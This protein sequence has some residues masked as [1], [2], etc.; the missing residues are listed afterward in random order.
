MASTGEGS[1]ANESEGERLDQ[2]P[3]ALLCT[4]MSKL[5][6]GSICSIASTCTAFRASASHLFG[7]I[8]NFHLL[9]RSLKLDCE[10]LDDSAISFV[11]QPSLQE[12]CVHN[13]TDFSG[14]LLSEIGGKCPDLRCLYLGSVAE[15]R[16]RAIHISD[17]EEL[18]S[19][20]RQLEVRPWL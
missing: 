14:K 6:V 7:F 4:I 18:L 15:K 2:M 16:G 10:R 17:L 11:A 5:D 20:C 19:G 12:L 13:C 3:G 8:P 1:G 9:L